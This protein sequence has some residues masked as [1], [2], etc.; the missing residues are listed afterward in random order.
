MIIGAVGELVRGVLA[1]AVVGGVVGPVSAAGALP[2]D[3]DA[4]VD[5]E[6]SGEQS[7]GELCGEGEQCAGPILAGSQTELAQSFAEVFGADRPTGPAAGEQPW[8]G[9]LVAEG[10]VAVAG[11]DELEDEFGERFGQHDRFAAEPKPYLVFVVVD[12]LEVRRATAA[13]HW[14]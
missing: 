12:V 14:A 9:A 7:G 6:Q 10:G 5:A 4:D 8:G 2:G 3:S 11:C 1:A 13:G